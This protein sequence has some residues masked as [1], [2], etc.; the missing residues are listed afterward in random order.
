MNKK[1]SSSFH[2][3]CPPPLFFSPSLTKNPPSLR[4]EPPIPTPPHEKPRRILMHRPIR[5]YHI[6]NRPSRPIHVRKEHRRRHGFSRG[7]RHGRGLRGL[8]EDHLVVC[9]A[10]VPVRADG[11][12]AQPDEA[13]VVEGGGDGLDAV[14]SC[15]GG[16]VEVALEDDSCREGWGVRWRLGGGIGG[17][18]L[19]L[20]KW[21]PWAV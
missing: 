15:A 3:P 13:D 12:G 7:E 18:D 10:L 8:V 4:R 21:L 19:Y 1:E 20:P 5:A 11:V 2:F 9:V 16:G 14:G 17:S 6:E